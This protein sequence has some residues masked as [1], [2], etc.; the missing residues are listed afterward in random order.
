MI[1]KLQK[2]NKISLRNSDGTLIVN[3]K[4]ATN[5]IS[6]NLAKDRSGPW[7]YSGIECDNNFD[8]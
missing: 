7:T 5:K 8:D 6:P 1:S 4:D 3:A 2:G